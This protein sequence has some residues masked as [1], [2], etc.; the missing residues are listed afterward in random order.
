MNLR[1]ACS[2][3]FLFIAVPAMCVERYEDL[4]CWSPITLS[5]G[6]NSATIPPTNR[7]SGMTWAE[8]AV[9]QTTAGGGT[10]TQSLGFE[11]ASPG[12]TTEIQCTWTVPETYDDTGSVPQVTVVGWALASD[13][14]GGMGNTGSRYS[15]FSVASRAYSVNQEMTASWSTA[16]TGDFTFACESCGFGLDCRFADKLK[17]VTID[18]AQA[19]SDWDAGDLVFIRIQRVSVNDNFAQ[20]VHVPRVRLRWTATQ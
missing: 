20:T 12:A 9:E 8:Q 14:C 13:I 16:E 3:V 17:S 19:P 7:A 11:F 15:R 2:V 18:A 4:R 10:A 6:G 1:V 5:V